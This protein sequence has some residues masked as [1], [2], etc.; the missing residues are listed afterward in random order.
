M[1]LKI[2]WVRPITRRHFLVH[3][4]RFGITCLSHLQITITELAYVTEGTYT[5][6]L[7][8]FQRNSWLCLYCHFVLHSDHETF[9]SA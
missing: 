9:V 5:R 8:H 7:L 1:L 6:T 2:F 3:D 4:Q